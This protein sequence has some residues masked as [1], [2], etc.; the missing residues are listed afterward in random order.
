MIVLKR[1]SPD[2]LD[3]QSLVAALDK[4]LW[5]RYPSTQQNFAPHNK[6]DHSVS[7]VVAYEKDSPVGCGCFRPLIEEK[8]I[9]IKRMYVVPSSRGMGIARQ[10]L[11]E[12]EK[13][14]KELGF[15]HSKLETGANQPEAIAVYKRAQ[16]RQIPNYPPYTNMEES[17]C[18]AKLLS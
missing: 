3:F 14:G 18:M 16:Y 8:G 5:V 10:V 7:V 17:I 6:L 15:A 9:E 12:L 11:A 4:E 1:T 13:W 2:D